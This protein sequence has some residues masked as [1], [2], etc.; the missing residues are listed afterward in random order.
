[1][2]YSE[3]GNT[4]FNAREG[5]YDYLVL[6]LARTALFGLSRPETSPPTTYR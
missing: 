3:A 2:K 4:T 5:A 6:A 1:M